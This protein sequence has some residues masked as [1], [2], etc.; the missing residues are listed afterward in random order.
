MAAETVEA[1]LADS[2]NYPVPQDADAV[3][4]SFVGLAFYARGLEEEI[5]ALKPKAKTPGRQQRNSR[6][7]LRV[8]YKSR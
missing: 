6:A 1:I 7:R 5:A 3:R 8:G 4:E 2:N